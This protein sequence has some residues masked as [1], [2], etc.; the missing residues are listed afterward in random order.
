[1][2]ATVFKARSQLLS[3]IR[4]GTL[5]Q[6]LVHGELGR[7][8]FE[9]VLWDVY[10]MLLEDDGKNMAQLEHSGIES[11]L[12]GVLLSF[13]DCEKGDDGWPIETTILQLTAASFAIVSDRASV[14]REGPGINREIID[15]LEPVLLG[16]HRYPHTSIPITSLYPEHIQ[17]MPSVPVH[18]LPS[19][20]PMPVS[21]PC[22][23]EYF[24]HRLSLCPPP[25]APSV[26]VIITNRQEQV[27][28]SYPDDLSANRAEADARGL[29]GATKEE[30]D[31]MNKF[32]EYAIG[33]QTP[34][35]GG[36]YEN[37]ACLENPLT[38]SRRW[39]HVFNRMLSAAHFIQHPYPSETGSWFN[40]VYTP[41]MYSGFWL[42][43][44]VYP[45]SRMIQKVHQMHPAPLS[46]VRDN[47]DDG[48]LG[49]YV[50]F[51]QANLR[52]H[53]NTDFEVG[54][55]EDDVGNGV[56]NG[57]FPSAIDPIIGRNMFE[58]VSEVVINDPLEPE[59][60]WAIK[61]YA[62]WHEGM[63]LS[64][65]PPP[66]KI[67]R[68]DSVEVPD[69]VEMAF[70]EEGVGFSVPHIDVII[71][72]ETD[73]RHGKAFWPYS[74]YGRVR[75][76]DGLIIIVRVLQD[77]D[78]EAGHGRWVFSGNM[79]LADTIVGT[80]REMGGDVFRPSAFQAPFIIS[81][82]GPTFSSST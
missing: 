65:I 25:L 11:W 42:G 81:R 43:R 20:A 16:C 17:T 37:L 73:Y 34:R 51:F 1:M 61:R 18:S 29:Q 76:M 60:E 58:A 78:P 39:D 3:Q 19:L 50:N 53:I 59:P 80:W 35:A 44:I 31:E 4:N 24:G 66:P 41:G 75:R 52:E 32:R 36:G 40:T 26:A 46:E 79:Q 68:V 15:A 45:D 28:I 69:D 38:G 74:F 48:E 47:L 49:V 23:L 70:D 9:D 27:S 72:G 82:L 54:C 67:P 12:R 63:E 56:H 71:T 57:G 14:F 5:L 22:E 8:E 55:G 13:M 6:S 64:N 33:V 10:L 62:T 77:P 21:Q 2:F 30:W 7:E